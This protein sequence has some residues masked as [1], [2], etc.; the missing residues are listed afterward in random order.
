MNL[1]P[2]EAVALGLLANAGSNE[3][4]G[5]EMVQESGHAIK[6]G[7]VYVI[8][9][10]LQ[11]KGFVESRKEPSPKQAIPRRLYRITGLGS[12]AL[13]AYSKAMSAY[14][15]AWNTAGNLA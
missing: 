4:Y 1:T 5:Y 13:N 12:R 6:L 10:R 9:S 14:S 7:S 15:R 8:L 2:T 3:K 11:D